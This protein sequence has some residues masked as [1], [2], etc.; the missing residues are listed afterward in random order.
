MKEFPKISDA[1]WQVMKVIWKNNPITASKIIDELKYDT[2]WNSKTIHTLISRLV[3]KEAIGIEK[4]SPYY[5][6]YPV[7][8][9][10]ECKRVETK[11]FLKKVYDGSLQLL[12]ANFIKDDKFTKNEIEELQRIL[13]KKK[14]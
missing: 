2:T 12:V 5:L 9:E 13:D 11:S 3:K 8:S 7:V 1:E 14:D 10:E 6:Y 4:A